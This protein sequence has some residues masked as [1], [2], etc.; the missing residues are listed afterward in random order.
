MKWALIL[1]TAIACNLRCSHNDKSRTSEKDEADIVV[2]SMIIEHSDVQRIT[3]PHSRFVPE[4][5]TQN[6]KMIKSLTTLQNQEYNENEFIWPISDKDY[7]IVDLTQGE[8]LLPKPFIPSGKVLFVNSTLGVDDIEVGDLTELD[9]ETSAI[10][11]EIAS[12]PAKRAYSDLVKQSNNLTCPD[13]K[14]NHRYFIYGK[15]EIHP[16]LNS[17]LIV[18]EICDEDADNHATRSMFLL[19]AK[20]EQVISML[21]IANSLSSG[22]GSHESRVYRLD[23]GILITRT[24]SVTDMEYGGALR[25]SLIARNALKNEAYFSVYK[26]LETGLI[27]K[28]KSHDDMPN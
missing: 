17:Y 18:E 15:V 14:I 2:D 20:D 23:K 16:S 8:Y 22:L 10:I 13:F 3:S 5:W 9:K 6:K 4:E 12:I 24:E 19:N 26:V 7:E 25:D 21:N 28:L 11:A 27:E 1:I